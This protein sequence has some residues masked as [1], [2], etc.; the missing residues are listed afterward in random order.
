M[1]SP[2]PKLI[3]R[4]QALFELI[5]E[6]TR[7]NTEIGDSSIIVTGTLFSIGVLKFV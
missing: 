1:I 2:I 7:K 3:D 5:A 4:K 6:I